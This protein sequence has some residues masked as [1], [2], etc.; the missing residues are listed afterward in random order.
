MAKWAWRNLR[1]GMVAVLAAV[2]WT[3]CTTVPET[4]RTQFNL[5]SGKWERSMG[6]QAF[7]RI[8]AKQSF[9]ED[10]EAAA[11]VQ[12]VGRR[13][14]AVAPLEGAQWEFALFNNSEANAFCLPGGKV[15]VYTGILRITQ[16]EAGLATVL[17]HEV[18]HAAAHHSAE[19][20]SRMIAIQGAGIALV[21]SFGN[22]SGSSRTMLYAAWGIG[23]TVGSELPHSRRQ[24]LEADE[25]GLLYMARAGYDP[26]EAVRF[27]ERF[28]AHNKSKGRNMPWFLR[29]HPLDVQRIERLKALLPYAKAEFRPHTP[30][31]PPAVNEVVFIHPEDGR[32][33]TVPWKER[34]T[35]YGAR[36]TAQISRVG[37]E[38]T[39][40]RGGDDLPGAPTL[41]LRPGDVVRWK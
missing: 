13:I 11:M 37:A 5:V 36:R 30:S 31:L 9:S 10:Q 23:T 25:I 6:R 16:N 19:R 14:A 40:Q 32:R 33:I 1:G 7:N 41:R 38:A 35:L 26:E 20:V 29:T 12:R 27:W 3:G 4:G 18:A 21:N 34:L 8:K 39:V 22:L 28:A 15:G 17:A 2:M 24:E